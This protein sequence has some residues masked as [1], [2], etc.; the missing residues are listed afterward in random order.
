MRILIMLLAL[1]LI[2]LTACKP[3]GEG[4]G[5]IQVLEDGT[6]YIYHKKTG[7]PPG[8]PSDYVLFHVYTGTETAV[9]NSS[10][11]TGNE[12]AY[13]I[14]DAGAPANPNSPVPHFLEMMGKGDSL[15][16]VVNLDTL[17]E[18]PPGFENESMLYYSIAIQDIQSNAAYEVVL[19][20]KRSAAE[21]EAEVVKARL[22]E[23]EALVQE[24]VGKYSSGSLTSLNTLDSGLKIYTIEEGDGETPNSG[25]LV[26]VLYY[27]TLADGTRFDDAFSRGASFDFP[28][29]AGRV[30][31]G[32][33]E[34]IAQLKKGSKAFL[35]I[36]PA[37]GYGA[38]GSP[39]VI[40]PDAELVFY[41]ELLK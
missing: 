28:I 14:P 13:Q 4:T 31:Q 1:S 12:P 33:D 3:G 37:M 20:E 27:G 7:N 25:E 16:I 36:P 9:V 32:W 35:F 11:E 26:K 34:G 30:I 41:V 18:K 23:V 5:E 6:Q 21:K 17:P 2:G 29:G 39:P 22:S 38:A 19:E 24:T 15:T 8:N 10:R 40:P